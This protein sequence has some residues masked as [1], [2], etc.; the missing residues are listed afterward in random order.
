MDVDLALTARDEAI[1]DGNA[2]QVSV[3]LLREGDPASSLTNGAWIRGGERSAS[4]NR[5]VDF[6]VQS[7]E[8][9]VKKVQDA[10]STSYDVAE[11]GRSI[12]IDF[13]SLGHPEKGGY[14]RLAIFTDMSA[15]RDDLP[16]VVPYG[17][18]KENGWKVVLGVGALGVQTIQDVAQ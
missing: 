7:G 16:L 13:K 8:I 12:A 3:V 6:T 1:N 18:I 17:A 9:N 15:R 5:A 10:G 4:T 11:D 14:S 2:F